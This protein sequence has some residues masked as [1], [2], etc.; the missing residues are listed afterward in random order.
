[1]S[2]KTTVN[3]AQNFREAGKCESLLQG[4]DSVVIQARYIDMLIL[5]CN[6]DF[7]INLTPSLLR[8]LLSDP[9][10]L[11]LDE[12]TNHLDAAARCPLQIYLSSIGILIFIHQSIFALAV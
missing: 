1:M 6:V 3:Y 4:E 5:T 2:K 11:V 8:L 12:P 9:D 10:I 7:Y